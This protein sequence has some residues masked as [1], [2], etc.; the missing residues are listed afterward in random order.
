MNV[1]GYQPPQK[2]FSYLLYGR[3]VDEPRCGRMMM[4]SVWPEA[5]SCLTNY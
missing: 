1:W 2:G 5:P 4:P 3:R